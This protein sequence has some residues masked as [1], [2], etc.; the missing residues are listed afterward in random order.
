MCTLTLVTAEVIIIQMNFKLDGVPWKV[1]ISPSGLMTIGFDDTKDK[2]KSFGA[3]V[4]AYDY[5]NKGVP[6]CFSAVS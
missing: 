1:K 6:K 2:S 5:E 4:A 3:I